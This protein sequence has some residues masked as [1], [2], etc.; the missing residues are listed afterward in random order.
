[1]QHISLGLK[2]KEIRWGPVQGE[3]TSVRDIAK[4][5]FSCNWYIALA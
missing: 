2:R 1:M 5:I 3:D 4:F